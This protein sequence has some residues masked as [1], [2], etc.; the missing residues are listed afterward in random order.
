MTLKDDAKFEKNLTCD[1]ENDMRNMSNFHQTTWKFQNW[2]FDGILFNELK[3]HRGVM[4]HDN[5]EWCKIWRGIDLSF[6]NW[7]DEFDKYA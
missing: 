7:H 3:I 2:D 4:C 6:Q 1:L 5:E